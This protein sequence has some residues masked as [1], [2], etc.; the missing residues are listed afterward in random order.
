MFVLLSVLVDVADIYF[1]SSYFEFWFLEGGIIKEGSYSIEYGVG[2]CVVSGDKIGFVY[3]DW[4]ELLIL[5]EVVNNVKVIV[6]Y[7]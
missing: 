3:S 5:L 2:V 6:C 1:Q 7:G 4:I